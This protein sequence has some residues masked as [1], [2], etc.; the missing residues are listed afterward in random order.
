MA[1]AILGPISFAISVWDGFQSTLTQWITRYVSIYLWLP[2]ADLF[3]AILAKIQV[4]MLQKDILELQNNPNYSADS[5]NGVYIVFML[6]VAN[7]IISSCTGNFTR[8]INA[9]MIKTDNTAGN[10]AG[11]ILSGGKSGGKNKN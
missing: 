6:T 10:T 1:L 4:L 8:N 11:Q 3:S 5:A 7:W 2:V 9:V